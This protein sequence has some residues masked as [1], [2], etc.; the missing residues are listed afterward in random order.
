MKSGID[1][2]LLLDDLIRHERTQND[3][4]TECSR[5]RSLH[6]FSYRRANYYNISFLLLFCHSVLNYMS[7][8]IHHMEIVMCMIA[9]YIGHCLTVI[10]EVIPSVTEG[11]ASIDNKKRNDPSVTR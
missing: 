8:Q 10:M 2:N 3:V 11:L 9:D 7:I 5:R 6:M 4:R 1:D